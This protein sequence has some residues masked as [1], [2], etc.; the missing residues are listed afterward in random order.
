MGDYV[1]TEVSHRI[2]ATIN[3]SDIGIRWGGEEFVILVDDIVNITRLHLKL[4][5]HAT[6]YK[7]S[8]NM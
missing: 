1:L 8:K 2:M 4:N 3:K 5:T 7:R 6:C